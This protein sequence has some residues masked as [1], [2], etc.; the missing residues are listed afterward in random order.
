M[1]LKTLSSTNVGMSMQFEK[2]NVSLP[3]DVRRSKTPSL[4]LPFSAIMSREKL[5][6]STRV[7]GTMMLRFV[8]SV[9]KS[10]LW[11]SA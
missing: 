10:M 5:M 3:V 1:R 8:K 7:Q 11:T 4:K 6:V 9:V 2:K